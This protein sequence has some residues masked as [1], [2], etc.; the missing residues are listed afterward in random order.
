MT[1]APRWAERFNAEQSV[2]LKSVK[3][4]QSH[5]FNF[6]PPPPRLHPS[7]AFTPR[8]RAPAPVTAHAV[9]GQPNR[10]LLLFPS[11]TVTPPAPNP[12]TRSAAAA[13]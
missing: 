11:R 13:S 5:R 1:H 2:H 10:P 8:S 9:G 6:G 3:V 7:R 4:R 12:S